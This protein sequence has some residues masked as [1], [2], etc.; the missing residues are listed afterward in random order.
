[1]VLSDTSSSSTTYNSVCKA[2]HA[3]SHMTEKLTM[4]EVPNTLMYTGFPLWSSGHAQ[5]VSISTQG[6]GMDSCN[7]ED[8]FID[9]LLLLS[10]PIRFRHESVLNYWERKDNKNS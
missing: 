2:S 9:Y 7:W 1:M 6:L 3:Y 4:I 8:F 5:S 10:P